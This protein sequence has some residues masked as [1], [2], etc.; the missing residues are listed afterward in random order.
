MRWFLRRLAFYVFALWVA[1]TAN[2]VLPRLMPGDPIGGVMQH[3]SPS[4]IQSNPG[5][6]KL[7]ESLLGGGKGGF[8]H[9]YW[10]YLGH[11]VHMN[12]GVSYS[13][14]PAS[15]SAVVGRTLPY[16]IFLV[17]VAFILAFVLGIAIGTIAAWR[18]GGAFD[19][20]VVPTFMALGAFP[21]FFTALLAVY[22][23]GLK[24]H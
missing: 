23:L 16:S 14:Y 6:V 24:L 21:S 10:A 9:D 18:R 11:I 12:F 20:I 13:N 2:F 17:G 1:I 15:V 7:Y 8:F 4:Q 5:I 3:L 22:F 19:G